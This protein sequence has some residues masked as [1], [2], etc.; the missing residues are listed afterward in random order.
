VSIMYTH[1]GQQFKTEY[2]YQVDDDELDNNS[3]RYDVQ[4]SMS[5]AD[6]WA[7]HDQNMLLDALQGTISCYLSKKYHAPDGI[8]FPATCMVDI[9]RIAMD[10]HF[11]ELAI[12]E[13][14]VVATGE[15]I[16]F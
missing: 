3:V 14:S 16:D 6:Y 8:K 5:R 4:M 11:P 2:C 12:V 9:Q 15:K 1:K 10:K 13:F 7:L